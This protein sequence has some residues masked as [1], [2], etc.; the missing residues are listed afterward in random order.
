MAY[1]LTAVEAGARVE[2]HA[3]SMIDSGVVEALDYA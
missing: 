2:A 1:A 3:A